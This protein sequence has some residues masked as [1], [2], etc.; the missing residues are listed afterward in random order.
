MP[1]RCRKKP[2]V[3]QSSMLLSHTVA[4][5]APPPDH[6][7]ITDLCIHI[8][9]HHSGPTHASGHRICNEPELH[10]GVNEPFA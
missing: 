1:S 5:A 3:L 4:I 6:G 7:R 2:R 9:G 8:I 10:F